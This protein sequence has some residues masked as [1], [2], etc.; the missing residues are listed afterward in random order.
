MAAGF[1][2]RHGL[3]GV[4]NGSVDDLTSRAHTLSGSQEVRVEGG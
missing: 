2:N 3:Q 4:G 1:F